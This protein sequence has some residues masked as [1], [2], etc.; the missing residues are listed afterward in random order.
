MYH[1]Q[2]ESIMTLT[3]KYRQQIES[4]LER[5]VRD[6]RPEGLYAP[7]SYVLSLGGK[8]IRPVLCLLGCALYNA[9][10]VKD[11]LYPLDRKSTRLNSSH[12]RISYA[13][14]CLKKKKHA[15]HASN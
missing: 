2:T 11:S 6:R 13:V 12:V 15:Q 4:E 10:R 3:E 14:F 1:P 7:V 9:E 8:R 5:L